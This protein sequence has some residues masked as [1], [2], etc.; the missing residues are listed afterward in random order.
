MA[1]APGAPGRLPRMAKPTDHPWLVLQEG[2]R[3]RWGGDLR[4]AFIFRVLAERTGATI[5]RGWSPAIVRA[6]LAAAAGPRRL[7]SLRRQ[8]P[9]VAS[10]E[11]LGL[12]AIAAIRRRAVPFALDVHDDPLAQYKAFGIEA[13]AERLAE[14]RRLFAANLDAFAWHVAPS[15]SFAELTGLT[16]ERTI[17]APNGTD[18]SH[19]RPGPL[20]VEPTIGFISGAAAGRGIETLVAAARLVRERLPGLRLRLWLVAT[21]DSGRGYLDGLAHEL[22]GDAWIQIAAA[23]YEHV[24]ET[25]AGA[26][27]LC[28]PHPDNPYLDSALPIKLFDSMAAGRPLVVTP[29]VETRRVVEAA[30]AGIVASG[31][32]PEDLADALL[33]VLADPTLA[34]R[35]GSSG[36][37]AVERD[38][39]WRVIGER[40][41]SE[42]LGRADS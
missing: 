10:A 27:V 41:A 28:I 15:A 36:R 33:V 13:P 32:R 1:A 11:S 5:G 3:R 17:V 16:P 6:G 12:P 9:F 35:M 37:A 30:E 4:R 34:A 26:T 23:P 7:P 14:L 39:D 42:L 24:G 8:K 2:D 18:T 19:I 25:L 22:S 21:G 38:Y 20:P 29:R 40:L 31:D